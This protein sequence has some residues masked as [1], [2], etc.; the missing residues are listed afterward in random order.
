MAG[1]V[2]TTDGVFWEAPDW[3][4]DRLMEEMIKELW[5]LD[6]VTR[7]M[8]EQAKG[9]CRL[10][11]LGMLE[12]QQ[13]VLFREAAR[14]VHL[15]LQQTESQGASGTDALRGFMDVVERWIARIN[16]AEKKEKCAAN[17]AKIQKGV[18]Q[19]RAGVFSTGEI[20]NSFVENLIYWYR[21]GL[22]DC[23]DGCLAAIPSEWFGDLDACFRE[24]IEPV[25]YMPTGPMRTEKDR[26]ELRPAYVKLHGL[27]RAR[28]G[29]RND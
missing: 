14:R 8:C 25:D 9:K 7:E 27:I 4:F 23:W 22:G 19:A 10:I 28:M 24:R 6:P 2:I 26:S 5:L 16:E 3:A 15:R 12:G 1:R 11:D 29:K 18:A 17:I 13:Q 21:K 20:C